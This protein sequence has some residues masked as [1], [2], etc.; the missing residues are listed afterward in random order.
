[1]AKFTPFNVLR[2]IVIGAFGAVLSLILAVFFRTLNIPIYYYNGELFSFT[3]SP[4]SVD[5]RNQIISTGN[6]NII[7]ERFLS[8][9]GNGVSGLTTQ[10]FFSVLVGGVMLFLV[11]RFIVAF[12]GNPKL[13]QFA[14]ILSWV[15]GGFIFSIFVGLGTGLPFMT[16]LFS[17]T[18]YTLSIGIITEI[19][20]RTVKSLQFLKA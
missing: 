8:L 5:L 10:D 3:A 12:I 9:F 15:I 14:A 11:G 2:T 13:Q 16:T 1:M 4:V 7:G 17:M 20:L 19:L 18:V 6:F